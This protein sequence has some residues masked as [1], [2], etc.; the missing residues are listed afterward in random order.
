[1]ISKMLYSIYQMTSDVTRA[2]GVGAE[3]QKTLPLWVQNLQKGTF[4]RLSLTKFD[5]SVLILVKIVKIPPLW[6]QIS[7]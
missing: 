6:M 4:K 2:V 7:A 3:C 1:M 5:F